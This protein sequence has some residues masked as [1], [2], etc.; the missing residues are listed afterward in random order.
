MG[1]VSPACLLGTPEPGVARQYDGLRAILDFE[2]GE[3]VR[4]VVPDCLFRKTEPCRDLRVIAALCDQLD[5]IALAR[6]ELG[7]EF[8][9]A[10]RARQKRLQLV[11]EALP[12][13][14]R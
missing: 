7:E 12:R 10:R 14:L 13:G 8:T 9:T 11:L 1:L 2:L 3:N 5:E 4:D 6:R